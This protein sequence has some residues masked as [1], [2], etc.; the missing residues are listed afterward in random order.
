VFAA[1]AA[2]WTSAEPPPAEPPANVQPAPRARHVHYSEVTLQRGPCFG[3]CPTYVVTLHAD[4][5]IEWDGQGNVRVTGRG[6]ANVAAKQF[7]ELARIVDEVH[8]FELDER[9]H[10]PDPPCDPN[11]LCRRV[12]V[13]CTDTSHAIITVQHVDGMRHVVDDAHCTDNPD[14]EAL[15]TAIDRLAS[16]AKWVR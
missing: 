10:I 6:R 1:V 14:L 9:G 3:T 2:C 5:R 11:A 12:I 16:T 15:E 4:G 13:T 8:F 7:A